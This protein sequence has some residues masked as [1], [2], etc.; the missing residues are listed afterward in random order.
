MSILNSLKK[1]KIGQ[2][3]LAYAAGAWIII[4]IIDVMGGRWG[5]G[6]TLARS[7]DVTLITGFFLVVTVAW[8]HGDKGHQK[9][10]MTELLLVTGFLLAGV[11]GMRS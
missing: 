10:V 9:V 5:V 1:R 7:V 2:W 6:E 3:S 8:Y 4:Q 11:A